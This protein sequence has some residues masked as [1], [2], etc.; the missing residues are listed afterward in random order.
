LRKRELLSPENPRNS[1]QYHTKTTIM[2][3]NPKITTHDR[4][5]LLSVT[6]CRNT[7]AN[8]LLVHSAPTPPS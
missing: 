6:T 4:R 3:D 7:T 1:E 2:T 5:V 8:V